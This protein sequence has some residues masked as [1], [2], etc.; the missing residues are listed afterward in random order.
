MNTRSIRAPFAC[1]ALLAA[2]ASPPYAAQ[3]IED[4]AELASSV[5]VADASLHSVIRA[6][7]P[8]LERVPGTNQLVIEHILKNTGTRQISSNV[9]DH[10]FLR[11]TPGNVDDRAPVPGE[12][13][14]SRLV[15]Q[16]EGDRCSN[17]HW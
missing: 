2:C 5:V 13:P 15:Y 9:Y 7:K 10:N 17:D 6:G 4:D 12:V 14:A 3:A 1:L 16:F 11:L 8:R